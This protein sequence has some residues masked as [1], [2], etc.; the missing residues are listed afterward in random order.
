MSMLLLLMAGLGLSLFAVDGGSSGENSDEGLGNETD[1][2]SPNDTIDDTPPEPLALTGGPESDS[3]VGDVLDDTLRGG[4]GT[5]TLRGGDGDDL[6]D[7]GIGSDNLGGGDGEDT[8]LG[9]SGSDT[10]WGGDGNDLLEGGASYEYDSLNGGDGE[11]TLNGGDG[12]DTLNGNGGMD[13]FIGG[14][15]NDQIIDLPSTRY[16]GTN[17]SVVDAGAGDDRI[18]VE[19]GSTITTGEGRDEVRIDGYLADGLT[20]TLTDFDPSQDS[21]A[22]HIDLDSDFVGPIDILQDGDD[23]ILQSADGEQSMTVLGAGG[24]NLE[25]IDIRYS[26]DRDGGATDFVGSAMS[27]VVYLNNLDNVVDGGAGDDY[28][29][30]SDMRG[31][32]SGGADLIIGGEG[33][34]VIAGQGEIFGHVSNPVGDLAAEEDTLDGGLGN[35]TLIGLNGSVM[36]GGEG[37]DVFAIEAGAVGAGPEIEVLPVRIMDFTPG[38]DIVYIEQTNGFG[39]GTTGVITLEVWDNGLGSNV[40]ANGQVIAEVTGGQG[41]TLDDVVVNA[42]GPAANYPVTA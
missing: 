1:P 25:D 32:S 33:D 6:L 24:V 13:S 5:D 35:D 30:G 36:I 21:L 29:L 16:E 18:W 14:D 38:E 31:G 19:N 9:G 3:L 37:N 15:G 4:P 34:D 8:L 2:E 42:T 39:G 17:T 41:L 12:P 23:L 11:D 40:L 26:M 10:L 28:L 7:G 27:D 22:L 20:T